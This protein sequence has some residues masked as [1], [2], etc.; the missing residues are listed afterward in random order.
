MPPGLLVVVLNSYAFA[1]A[2]DCQGAWS[3]RQVARGLLSA[4]AAAQWGLPGVA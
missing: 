4:L 3:P 1:V 2:V